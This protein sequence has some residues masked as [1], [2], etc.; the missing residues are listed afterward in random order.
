MKAYAGQSTF[1]TPVADDFSR[2]LVES[3]LYPVDDSKALG[4]AG[5]FD[6]LKTWLRRQQ[7]N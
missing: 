5:V 6:G 7:W 2:S 4:R 3:G 1:Q